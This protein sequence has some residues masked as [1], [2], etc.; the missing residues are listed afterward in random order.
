MTEYD[1]FAQPV[2]IK[3]MSRPGL[4]QKHTLQMSG[5]STIIG[6]KSSGTC[7]LGVGK[8]TNPT[9]EAMRIDC[10]LYLRPKELKSHTIMAETHTSEDAGVLIVF[11]TED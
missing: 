9:M 2:S 1:K 11:M 5:A 7:S 8:R 10:N 3:P 6:S 4:S